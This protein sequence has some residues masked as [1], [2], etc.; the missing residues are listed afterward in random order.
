MRYI[1]Y[2]TLKVSV[3]C[4][5]NN[6]WR[7]HRANG[8]RQDAQEKWQGTVPFHL[9]PARTQRMRHWLL[10]QLLD[11]T[12][13]MKNVPTTADCGNQIHSHLVQC[14]ITDSVLSQSGP[15]K[16]PP[17][18]KF[19]EYFGPQ[20]TYQ[21][22]ILTTAIFSVLML[23]RSLG[24]RKW[25]SLGVLMAGVTLVQVCLSVTGHCLWYDKWMDL[26]GEMKGM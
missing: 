4:S 3:Q 7:N 17:H 20:V 5:Q 23:K 24:A 22:K 11:S 10:I 16:S 12:L 6:A 19:M 8:D 1:A 21:L 13:W 9:G 14:F 26:V 15:Q 2:S 18:P 25:L